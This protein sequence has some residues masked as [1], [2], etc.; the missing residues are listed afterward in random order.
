MT[1]VLICTAVVLSAVLLYLLLIFPSI[2]KRFSRE[3]TEIPIAHRG[4]HIKGV[5][6]NSLGAFTEAIRRVLPVEFDVRLTLDG[7]PVVFHDNDL[8]RMCGADVKLDS[9][10]YKELESYSLEGTTERIPTLS[11]VLELVDGKIPLLIELK[12]E[13]KS[14]VVLRV[15]QVLRDY[16]GT[17][18]VESF[19]PYHLMRFR[20]MAPNIPLGLLSGRRIGKT[21]FTAFFGSFAMNM[22]FN[23]LFRPDFIAFRY[24]D[25]LPFAIKLC[26]RFGVPVLG[27][28][29]LGEEVCA[30]YGDSFDGFIIDY[31]K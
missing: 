5:P 28:T 23:F 25:K 7:V 27:W 31:T 4:V 21:P 2:K 9:V 6:E 22:L 17:V 13:D 12:G 24:S 1:T 10:T 29:F 16:R 26:R 15:S 18:A 19:N 14:D 3:F 30:E 11:E 8:R 20:R